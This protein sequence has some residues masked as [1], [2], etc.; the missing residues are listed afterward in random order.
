MSHIVLIIDDSPTAVPELRS[1]LESEG[2]EVLTALR[3]EEALDTLRSAKVDLIITEALLPGMDGFDLVRHLKAN[4][5]WAIIPI[6]M[7]TVRSAPEDY[8]ASYDAGADEYFIKPLE[9]PK[10]IAAT[11]GLILRYE[12]MRVTGD[13]SSGRPSRGL[14]GP[15][16][17]RGE[18]GKII[19]VFSLKGGV[20]TTTLA[21]NLA[22]AIKMLEPSARVGLVDLS[23][24]QGIDALL[25]DIVPTST[26]AD[27]AREDL[28]DATPY[29]LNQYFVPHRTGISLM[30][31][32][33]SPEQAEIVRPDV[34]RRTLEL[35]PDAFDY[36]ILDTA[37]TFSESTLIALEMAGHILLPVTPD[38]AALKTAVNTLRI[39]K[40]VNISDDK[41]TMILNELV[42]RAGLTRQQVETSIGKNCMSVPHAGAGF[43]EA[44][45]TGMPLVTVEPAPAA[46]KAILD[47]ARTLCEPEELVAAGEQ[48]LG[49]AGILNR[50]RRAQ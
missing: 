1:L 9:P 48:K 30:S 42:P 38:M 37:S 46:A 8:A 19:G 33:S 44:S 13:I 24:E 5:R 14:P 32:P 47:I 27:W 36:I 43:I 10:I 20:G 25:L 4:E 23:L 15:V 49:R 41:T 50:L 7:L 17:V 18:R 40:A 22:V 31:A 28:T 12:K 29:L 16:S 39:L 3:A 2:Y 11:R 26:I 45:N 34:V 6:I 35:A 21:V